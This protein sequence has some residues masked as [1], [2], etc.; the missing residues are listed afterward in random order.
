MAFY[1][2]C[3]RVDAIPDARSRAA[4]SIAIPT[5]G[6]RTLLHWWRYALPREPSPKRIVFPSAARDH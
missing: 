1:K 6:Y 4:L 5:Q 2:Q 3:P